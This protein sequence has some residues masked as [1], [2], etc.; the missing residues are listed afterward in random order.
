MIWFSNFW[1]IVCQN[2]VLSCNRL[3]SSPTTLKYGAAALN[4][5]MMDMLRLL[6][7]GTKLKF[8]DGRVVVTTTRYDV[9]GQLT[10]PADY[11]FNLFNCF[12]STINHRRCSSS[13]NTVSWLQCNRSSSVTHISGCV[14]NLCA[15]FNSLMKPFERRE[16]CKWSAFAAVRALNKDSVS[17][18]KV[19]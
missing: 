5:I 10:G 17:W 15:I 11:F 4:L 3:L 13:S 9:G 7:I 14:C 1:H 6:W 8:A 12:S 18:K 19:H 16:N 2:V